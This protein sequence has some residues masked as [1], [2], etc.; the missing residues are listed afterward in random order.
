M[1]QRRY[2]NIDHEVRRLQAE[3]LQAPPSR[4]LAAGDRIKCPFCFKGITFPHRAR[5]LASRTCMAYQRYW[6]L[7]ESHCLPGFVL[8]GPAVDMINVALNSEETRARKALWPG[9]LGLWKVETGNPR[10]WSLPKETW[11]MPCQ[12][13]QLVIAWQAGQPAVKV[14]KRVVAERFD[15]MIQLFDS[16]ERQEETVAYYLLTG[17]TFSEYAQPRPLELLPS[18]FADDS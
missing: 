17:G 11:W 8:P 18:L 1:K 10:T 4:P 14:N 5:H 16:P 2:E 9:V 13:A 3:V 15:E 7:R 12:A 6:R